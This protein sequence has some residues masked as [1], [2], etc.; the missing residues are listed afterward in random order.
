[1]LQQRF[2]YLIRYTVTT[3]ELLLFGLATVG[4]GPTEEKNVNCG[5]SDE[6]GV[7]VEELRDYCSNLTSYPLIISSSR[8]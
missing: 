4:F 8:L 1:M 5:M 6:A 3:K 2:H 7:G